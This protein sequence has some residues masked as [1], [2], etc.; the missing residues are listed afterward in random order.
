MTE[1]ANTDLSGGDCVDIALSGGY[2]YVAAT[3]CLSKV[4]LSALSEL[5]TSEVAA[6][7]VAV[8]GD[9]AFVGSG[10]DG[11][12]SIATASM[13]ATD[14]ES[15]ASCDARG[16][17][18]YGDFALIADAS[19]GLA[20]VDISDPTAMVYRSIASLSSGGYY[21]AV[22][23]TLA[24][25]ASGDSI[26]IIGLTEL[27]D[28]DADYTLNIISRLG[29][30]RWAYHCQ[31]YGDM[32][33]VADGD[34]GLSV[35]YAK[36]DS[37]DRMF[38]MTTTAIN[39]SGV[40]GKGIAKTGTGLLLV[41]DSAGVQFVSMGN[42]APENDWA[43]AIDIG[44]AIA[45]AYSD[46][47]VYVSCQTVGLVSVDVSDP[48]NMDA[49]DTLALIP[50]L[51]LDAEG[52]KVYACYGST[53]PN[54]RVI[55]A[56]DPTNL[57]VLDDTTI[58]A[59]VW[60]VSVMGSYAYI[61]CNDGVRKVNLTDWNTEY[62][63]SSGFPCHTS[64][65]EGGYVYVAEN[66]GG[67]LILSSDDLSFVGTYDTDGYA[68]GVAK[69][70][71][72]CYVPAKTA[73]IY[74][75]DVSTP[76]SPEL[77]GWV[78]NPIDTSTFHGEPIS[79]G[80]Y[81]DY[82]LVGLLESADQDLKLI[83]KS[84]GA[85]EYSCPSGTWLA[86]DVVGVSNFV[87][88]ADYINGLKS[89]MI[90]GNVTDTLA[91][92]TSL[93]SRKINSGPFRYLHWLAQNITDESLSG[94]P[95]DTV[96]YRLIY[97]SNPPPET[98]LIM[99]NDYDPPDDPF[100]AR[101]YFDLGQNYDSLFWSAEIVEHLVYPTSADTVWRVD[102]VEVEYRTD[103]GALLRVAGGIDYGWSSGLSILFD[104]L[105]IIG[106]DSMDIPAEGWEPIWWEMDGERY[107]TL[108]LP[109]NRPVPEI[110]LVSS[111]YLTISP[112]DSPYVLL[113]VDGE[114]L[115][116]WRG[117]EAGEH[118]VIPIPAPRLRFPYKI[119]RGWNM[120][121]SP[122]TAPARVPHWG[123]DNLFYYKDG[124]YRITET[125]EPGRGYFIYSYGEYQI[126]DGIQNH[127]ME[128][129]LTEGWNL[130]GALSDP[131]SVYSL[132]TRPEDA[133]ITYSI[134]TL[135]STAGDYE[136]ATMLKSKKG[137]WVFATRPCTLVMDIDD[138]R[139]SKKSLPVVENTA[140][141]VLQT[142]SDR[143]VLTFGNNKNSSSGYDDGLDLILPPPIPGKN[144]IGHFQYTGYGNI[145]KRDIRPENECW[146]LII[147]Q[148][149]KLTLG[150]SSEFGAI[151]ISGQE[152]TAVVR[153][154]GSIRLPAG[155]YTVSKTNLISAQMPTITAIQS[156]AP[157]PFNSAVEIIADIAQG[158]A[159]LS[160]Y[161]L[162]GKIVRKYSLSGRGT[163]FIVWNGKD[164]HDISV[165]SGIYLTRIHTDDEA[166]SPKKLLLIR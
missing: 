61:S 47:Y 4:D 9:Y 81:G 102:T 137:Y 91:Q 163:H 159:N 57:T 112:I 56:S 166:S 8:K 116:S 3:S 148:D 94:D 40:S 100:G 101:T 121:S 59:T 145:L 70:G 39:V 111:V 6:Y 34:S 109:Y 24:A 143:Q 77:G 15:W 136:I 42:I 43:D 124:E 89:W 95:P 14:V 123:L 11:L 115:N 131:V 88:L 37:I 135:D 126:I 127:R 108:S 74:K 27:G 35:F 120:I 164:E 53:S 63:Y 20:A 30:K 51:G 12:R 92:N 122:A 76:S 21:L 86:E 114:P 62:T 75:I 54:F 52:D 117:L 151:N 139:M 72:Y 46:N 96:T 113:I 18:I 162:S 45:L 147:R 129:I 60:D 69:S 48:T 64:L 146:K 118:S 150:S 155:E 85:I 132:S 73:G 7:G 78:T 65:V 82:V 31:F 22:S 160:I 23:G 25:V 110:K 157:N 41:A 153:T 84:D 26:Y 140:R 79:V 165:P 93:R 19:N 33:I 49:L 44:D 1:L 38:I 134:Y 28:G 2:A 16:V 149:C 68:C 103:P 154:G 80:I 5:D 67:L 128:F 50:I 97:M 125:M 104:T 130:I 66:E 55:D 106:P 161:D 119:S 13:T 17:E 142:D 144:Y 10:T 71:D 83:A 156:I 98:L 107:S 158:E 99:E 32:L 29:A 138:V 133:I 105:A 141:L 36:E 90:R 87:L 152:I 58:S